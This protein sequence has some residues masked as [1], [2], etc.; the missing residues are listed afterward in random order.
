MSF[1]TYDHGDATR[2]TRVFTC[3]DTDIV[4]AAHIVPAFAYGKTGEYLPG[5]TTARRAPGD[6]EDWKFYHVSTYAVHDT[7]MRFRGGGAG[8]LS[9][10]E[11]TRKF[12]EEAERLAGFRQIT[13]GE[14]SEDVT[15]SSDEEGEIEAPGEDVAE[16]EGAGDRVEDA[17]SDE[18]AFSD[19]DQGS[20]DEEVEEV[21][22]EDGGWEDDD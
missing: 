7:L 11:A 20:G 10:R 18:S 22:E 9:T 5:E 17:G 14:V 1:Q 21:R 3:P 15:K 4:R 19:G 6:H 13:A 16:G 12:E 8:H 2:S